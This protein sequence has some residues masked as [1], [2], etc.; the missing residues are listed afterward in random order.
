LPEITEK[1]Y[2]V[3][4]FRVWYKQQSISQLNWS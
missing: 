2:H 4:L 3:K 1:L